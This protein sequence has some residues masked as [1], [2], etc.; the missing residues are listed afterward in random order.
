MCCRPY[1]VQSGSDATGAGS[2][3]SMF[4][5]AQ[6]GIRLQRQLDLVD[7]ATRVTALKANHRLSDRW[8]GFEKRGKLNTKANTAIAREM[9]GWCWAL[10]APLQ[11]SKKQTLAFSKEN[12]M[13]V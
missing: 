12:L 13:A 5:T 9:A 8:A 4:M 7:S 6:P 2:N 11:E 10:A 3:L 1:I